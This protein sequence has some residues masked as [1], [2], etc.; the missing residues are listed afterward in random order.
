MIQFSIHYIN[1]E[2]FGGNPLGPED[3]GNFD[4][5]QEGSAGSPEEY[6]NIIGFHG[7]QYGAGGNAGDE[8]TENHDQGD[9]EGEDYLIGAL[10]GVRQ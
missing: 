6:E 10:I 2:G 1:Q 5:K 8:I 7:D 4:D 3:T 9:S